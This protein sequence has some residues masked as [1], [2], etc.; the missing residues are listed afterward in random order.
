MTTLTRVLSTGKGREGTQVRRF[1]GFRAVSLI[2]LVLI[3]SMAERQATIR[4]ADTD[5]GILISQLITQIQIGMAKAQ[6]ELADKKIPRLKSVTLDLSTEAKIGAG[7]KINLYIFSFGKKWERD[8]SHEI[9]V[10]LKPPSPKEPLKVAAGPAISDQ[11]KD[12]IV[13]AANGIQTARQNPDVPLEASGLKVVLNFVVKGDTSGGV[14]FQIL[15]VTVDLSGDLA[16][17]A[18]QKITVLYENPEPKTPAK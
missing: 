17:S 1:L 6:K 2:V 4:A 7:G 14:N 5:E 9:E 16:N 11:L 10:T 12:A 3:A 18:V 8:R 13:S 15:P